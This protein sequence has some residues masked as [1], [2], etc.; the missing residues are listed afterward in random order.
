MI[1]SVAKDIGK[2]KKAKAFTPH[3]RNRV[4]TIDANASFKMQESLTK[5]KITQAVCFVRFVTGEHF[6]S[7]EISV[8]SVL[9]DHA[10]TCHSHKTSTSTSGLSS[11]LTLHKLG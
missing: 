5:A 11:S 8:A 6:I 2:C 3:T 1:N 7:E 4:K 9:E 10:W